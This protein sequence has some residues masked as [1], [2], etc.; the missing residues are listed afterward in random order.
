MANRKI[1]ELPDISGA[2]ASAAAE[3]GRHN[4]RREGALAVA[5]LD[6]GLTILRNSLFL[7]M[8][9]D[10]ELL[11]GR[12]SMLMPVSELKSMFLVNQ[13][14]EVYQIAESA[15]AAKQLG[16]VAN[17]EGWYLEWLAHLRLGERDWNGPIVERTKEYFAR[18]DDLRRSAFIDE[19]GR[20]LHESV[21]APLVLFRLLPLA[22]RLI[23][24]RAY[25]DPKIADMLRSQQIAL[26]P[27]IADCRECRGRVL[28]S[29][30]QCPKC[31][32][33]L[34]TYEWLT[35]TD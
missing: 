28:G 15:A 10:V 27:S 9:Q 19:M 24:A 7:R 33:P 22:I 8:H 17:P 21:A 35:A 6:Q 11:V 30:E 25:D 23:T 20:L 16:Y 26:L 29:G 13:A 32:N 5:W 2:M 12:D 18:T 4:T 14:I 31:G 3:F 34:W 1:P